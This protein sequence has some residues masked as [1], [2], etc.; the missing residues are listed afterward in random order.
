MERVPPD[1]ELMVSRHKED[2]PKGL[3]SSYQALLK[4]VQVV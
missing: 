2:V 1:P 3:L 4:N